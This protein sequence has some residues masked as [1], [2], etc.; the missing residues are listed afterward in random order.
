MPNCTRID[1][2]PGE[3]C[4]LLSCRAGSI[5]EVAQISAFE[6][7]DDVRCALEA[8]RHGSA[9]VFSDQSTGVVL[10]HV[11]GDERI[12]VGVRVAGSAG[13]LSFIEKDS[14]EAAG[15]LKAVQAVY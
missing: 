15:A 13:V 4:V 14:S 10:F 5:L 11:S 3:G 2:V 12:Q 1:G 9:R 8:G 7:Q 6:C